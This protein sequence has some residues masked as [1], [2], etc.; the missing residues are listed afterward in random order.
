MAAVGTRFHVS[1]GKRGGI[2]TGVVG[3]N[4]G[5]L[6]DSVLSFTRMIRDFGIVSGQLKLEL[7][8]VLSSGQG[9]AERALGA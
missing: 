6:R 8:M 1:P 3:G 5:G 2:R 9:I 7:I 4:I